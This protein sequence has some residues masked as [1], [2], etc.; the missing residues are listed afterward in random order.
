MRWDHPELGPIPPSE[1]IPIAEECGLIVELGAWILRTACQT[2]A[3]WRTLR[4]DASG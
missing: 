4:A 3:R 1:F 2:V